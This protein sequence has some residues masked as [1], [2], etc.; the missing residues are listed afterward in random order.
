MY[1]TGHH[2]SVILEH[3][4]VEQRHRSGDSPTTTSATHL[5]ASGTPT[6][7]AARISRVAR[8]RPPTGV[9]HRPTSPGLPTR[10]RRRR[11]ATTRR[12][13]PSLA[14]HGSRRSSHVVL[15]PMIEPDIQDGEVVQIPTNNVVRSAS[16]PPKRADSRGA[17]AEFSSPNDVEVIAAQHHRVELRRCLGNN[18]IPGGRSEGRRPRGSARAEATRD[19]GPQ[20]PHC[21]PIDGHELVARTSAKRRKAAKVS[22]SL[23]RPRSRRRYGPR[24][25]RTHIARGRSPR[26]G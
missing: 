3:K 8:R 26:Q 12:V 18:R 16:L 25:H 14:T 23:R 9:R 13:S 19:G 24:Q 17:D 21:E 15:L 2:E 5:A 6:S 10:R 20:N 7:T 11:S 1:V 4:A 22:C